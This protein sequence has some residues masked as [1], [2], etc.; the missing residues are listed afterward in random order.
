MTQLFWKGTIKSHLEVLHW[1]DDAKVEIIKE[2]HKDWKN[3]LLIDEVKY[4]EKFNQIFFWDLLGYENRTHR[5]PEWTIPWAGSADI[6]LWNFTDGK[7][8]LENVQVVCELKWAKTN[9]TKKQFWHGWLSPVGQGFAYKTWLKNCKRLIVSNF[10]EIRLYRDNTT[11]FEIWNL[12][13]LL[14]PKDNYFNLRTLYL[15]LHK[16]N[17]LSAKT[18]QLLSHFREE[19]QEITKKFYKEYKELRIELI[20]DM[21]HNNPNSSIEIV[22]EKAQKIIDRLIFIF[23]C[24]DKGLLPDKRLKE[25]ILKAWEFDFTPWEITKKFFSSVDKWSEKLGIPHGYNGWLFKEDETLNGLKIWDS[26]CRKFINLTNYNF[27]DQLSVNVLGHIFEQSI[28]DLENLKIDLL[29]TETQ[30]D[31][32]VDTGKWRR[33]KDW[34]FYTPEYIVDYIVQNSVMKYLNEKED[35]CLAK[36][37]KDETKAYQAYQ[38]ILQNIKVLDPACGSGAFLVRVFDVLF[39]ENK[40]VWSILNSLFDDT[41]TYK[42]IL[43]NNIYGVDLNAESVEIT[44]LSL[45]LKSAQKGKKLNNLDANIKCGNS[46]IDDPAIAWNKAFDWKK[47]F[48]EI[49]NKWSFDVIVGNPPYVRQELLWEKVKLYYK[50]VYPK[51]YNSIADLYVYF[52]GLALHLIQNKWIIWFISPNKRLE[53]SYWYELRKFLKWQ[54]IIQMVN[55]WELKIFEDASTEPMI[56][57]LGKNKKSNLFEYISIKSLDEAKNTS[58]HQFQQYNIDDLDESIWSFKSIVWSKILKKFISKQAVTL[59]SYSGNSIYYWIKTWI[60]KAFI[61]NEVIYQN[62]I[63]KDPN[64]K[65]IIKKLVEWDDFNKWNLNYSWRYL[66]NTWYDLDIPK[67][68]PVIYEWLSNFLPEVKNRSDQ[69]KNWWNLRACDYYDKFIIP[70]LI[71]Y[72]TALKHNFY[73]DT[74]WYYI[75]ANCYMITWVDRYLQCILNSSLFQY[76]KRFLFPAFWDAENWGR[77]RLD[78]NK[79]YN[80]PIKNITSEQKQKYEILAINISEQSEK[81]YDMCNKFLHRI[82]DNLK[83]EK[84]TKKLEKFYEWEFK[85]FLDELKKQKISLSLSDQDIR[86]PYFK[87]YKEKALLSK[88]EIE[89]TDKEIDEMVFDLYG[90]S[91]EERGVVEGK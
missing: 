7:Y 33:K 69:W 29:G 8:E 39:E 78:A 45:R 81:F 48:K 6:T 25:S 87:E 79:M 13:E 36:Y 44:K 28:S 75:S 40:R 73:Y 72:H 77:V 89:R 66:I 50:K 34:I 22:I 3:W 2:L 61:I 11:D 27:D 16:D 23:F 54:N 38:Q 21:R 10:Y 62:I 41:E 57:I 68:Y 24:E 91:E 19:Q 15:L 20:N 83:V 71:Y 55:F 43:T 17:L 35:E 80:V 64:S 46:L 18:E 52:Y 30:T 56:V 58:L 51:V 4:K 53:R 12:D 42:N 59:K 65:D 9:L 82:Q 84:I 37:K 90:L 85:D 88:G 67:D 26:I 32:L 76:V 70:K 31:Q 60:N 14:D 74:E 49:M 1:F 5:I 63:N 86:E 47:E